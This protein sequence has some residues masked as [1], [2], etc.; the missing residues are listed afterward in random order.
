MIAKLSP[1]YSSSLANLINL[2]LGQYAVINYYAAER[3]RIKHSS[4][5]LHREYLPAESIPAFPTMH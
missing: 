5:D 1:S 4:I 3:L 2:K